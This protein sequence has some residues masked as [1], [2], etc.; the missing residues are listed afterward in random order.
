[1]E[2]ELEAL[3]AWIAA[4]GGLSGFAALALTLFL[5]HN[6]QLHRLRERLRVS[7]FTEDV[8]N[9]F[10]LWVAYSPP[11]GEQGLTARV[12][13]VSPAGVEIAPVHGQEPEGGK[14]GRGALRESSDRMLISDR[15]DQAAHFLLK[16]KRSPMSLDRADLEIEIIAAGSGK[17]LARRRETVAPAART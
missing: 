15:G 3:G 10:H 17:V 8:R 13:I 4:V 2:G 12:R 11:D 6:D 7:A 16:R 14:P 1:M 9:A 5:R